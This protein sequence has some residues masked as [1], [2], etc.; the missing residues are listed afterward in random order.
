MLK[1]DLLPL[2]ISLPLLKKINAIKNPK[3]III[4][5]Y[6]LIPIIFIY[7]EALKPSTR[8]PLLLSIVINRVIKPGKGTLRSNLNFIF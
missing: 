6:Y 1:S 5:S 8:Y 7:R 3:V 2:L 4:H